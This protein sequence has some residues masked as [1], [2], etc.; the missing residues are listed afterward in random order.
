MGKDT[1]INN[2]VFGI[3]LYYFPNENDRERDKTLDHSKLKFSRCDLKHL[4]GVS[5]Y[6]IWNAE[7]LD[8]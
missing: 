8:M 7:N 2:F 4:L 3:I 5:P 6:T 1:T